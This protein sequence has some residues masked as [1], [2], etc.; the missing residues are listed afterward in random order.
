MIPK[1]MVR[2]IAATKANS[3]ATV[4]RLSRLK[5]RFADAPPAGETP[6]DAHCILLRCTI[7]KLPVSCSSLAAATAIA[8]TGR[9]FGQV[10]INLAEDRAER[11]ADVPHERPQANRNACRQQTVLDSGDAALIFHKPAQER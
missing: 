10:G 11:C 2:K 9:G 8:R 1:R 5:R 7:M 3:I 6:R 4:P